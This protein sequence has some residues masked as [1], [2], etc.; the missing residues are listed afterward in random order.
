M[1]IFPIL[2]ENF[3]QY[4][5]SINMVKYLTSL[6]SSLV[7]K[8]SKNFNTTSQWIGWVLKHLQFAAS[9]KS[10]EVKVRGGARLS[11][12]TRGFIDS[13]RFLRYN[14]FSKP[15][16]TGLH[17][18]IE[19]LDRIERWRNFQKLKIMHAYIFVQKFCFSFVRNYFLPS[20]CW[21]Y[22]PGAI[23]GRPYFSRTWLVK[24]LMTMLRASVTSRLMQLKSLKCLRTSNCATK[25]IST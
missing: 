17:S 4:V 15:G 25:R 1:L 16:W 23:N 18:E 21:R 24:Y 19:K 2:F 7:R 10:N 11:D 13:L 22:K 14:L 5:C 12:G 3:V 9:N 8:I 20:Y 6:Y